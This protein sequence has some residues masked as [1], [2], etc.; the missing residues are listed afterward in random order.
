M[1]RNGEQGETVIAVEFSK[2][3]KATIETLVANSIPEGKTLEYKEF[4]PLNGSEDRK[5]FLHDVSSFAN[6]SGGDLIYGIREKRDADGKPTGEPESAS[7]LGGINVNTEVSRLENMIRDGVDPR[8][9]VPVKV[10]DGFEQG[11]VLL[12]RIP[13][14][15]TSPH[16][17]KSSSKFYS[18]NSRGKYPLDVR[19]IRTAFSLSESLPERMRRFRD[20]RLAKIVADETPTTLM[21]G[22]KMV[23]HVLPVTSFESSV[24]L[25]L[26]EVSN[27]VKMRP[28]HFVSGG[29]P[30]FN[31]D[32][33]FWQS[34]RYDSK[35][36][37]YT[38]LFRNGAIEM[39]E[40]NVLNDWRGHPQ[41]NNRPLVAATSL[42]RE[43]MDGLA[44]CM[45]ALQ[46]LEV[47]P[48]LFVMLSFLGVKGHILYKANVVGGA[49]IDRDV[50]ILP[51]Q[52]IES[53]DD[54]VATILHTIFDS[55]WQAS[56]VSQCPNY[57]Q[58]GNRKTDG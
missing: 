29:A 14:S 31:L 53:Y 37:S 1:L 15:W 40:A 2:I 5:E 10:V 46:S 41:Y 36:N 47:L 18:R 24:N 45:D 22:A 17:V 43:V 20:D 33:V 56:G 3:D 50:V 51:E 4:L 55:M 26:A 11:P 16:M 39:V 30:R 52:L 23:L 58:S 42:E 6:A 35:I 44:K 8:V 48:P 28:M 34:E 57:D 21:A 12:L 9:T 54:P 38:Q 19:E 25:G 7:G 49:P 32:G 13:K 27:K